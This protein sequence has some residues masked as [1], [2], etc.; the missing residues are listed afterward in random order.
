[1]P[2]PQGMEVLR[3]IRES[4]MARK[5]AVV[6]LTAYGSVKLAVEAMR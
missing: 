2:P 4:N 6:I 3:H 1:M 5:P